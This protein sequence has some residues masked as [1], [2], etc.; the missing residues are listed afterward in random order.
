M[1]RV[2]LTVVGATLAAILIAGATAGAQWRMDEASVPRIKMAEFQKLLATNAV[3]V[4]DVRDVRS[5]TMGHIP[6]A[7]SIPVGTEMNRIEALKRVGKLIV[8]YCT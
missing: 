3:L 4:V 8:T 1:R 6:G 7:V 5:F 2:R